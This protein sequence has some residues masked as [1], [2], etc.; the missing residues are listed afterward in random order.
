MSAPVQQLGKLVRL[1]SSDHDGERLASLAAIDRTL[2]A[3]RLTWHDVGE[4]VERHLP[5]SRASST[6]PEWQQVAQE[7]LRQGGAY[8]LKQGE[9]QF[10]TSMSGWPSEPSAKQWTWLR[11]IAA[12]LNVE[13]CE[14]AA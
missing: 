10:L 5:Q 3:N 12:A 8:R 13:R 1:L 2:K 14:G 7:C 11:A 9:R 4:A 6:R